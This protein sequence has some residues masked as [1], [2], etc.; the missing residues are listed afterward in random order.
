MALPTFKARIAHNPRSLAG[1]DTYSVEL[2]LDVWTGAGYSRGTPFL[3][4]TGAEATTITAAMA[5][6]LSLSTVGGRPVNVRGASGSI[7]GILIPFR[8]RFAAWPDLE[9]TDSV[10]VV[11]SGEKERGLLAFR[12]VHPRLE[13]FKLGNDLFFVPPSPVP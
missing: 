4:D 12:D 10:C 9:V 5:R 11:A 8:F 3:F 7:A 2:V 6:E 13:F 1:R